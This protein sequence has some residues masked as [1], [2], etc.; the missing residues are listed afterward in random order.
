MQP[1]QNSYGACLSSLALTRYSRWGECGISG[2]TSTATYPWRVMS[3]AVSNCFAALRRLWSIRRLVSQPVLLS[4]VTSLIMVRL[5]YGSVTLAGLPG[6]LLDRL[7]S[8]L[9]AAARLVCY[10]QKYDQVTHLLQDLHCLRVPKGIQFRLAVLVF[11]CRNNMAPHTFSALFNGLMKQSHCNDYGPA[12]NS[13]WSYLARD[14]EPWVT[15]LSVWR[16]LVH[17]TVFQPLSLQ[18]IPWLP[19]KDN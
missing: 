14:Y 19:S 4:M 2:Y 15:A 13:G 10:A 9:N 7:Q 3:Q 8:V 11:R 17:G 18:L 16:L 1:E 12:L 6:H 5:D